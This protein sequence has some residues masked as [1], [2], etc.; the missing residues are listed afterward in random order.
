MTWTSFL[1]TIGGAYIL[2]YTVIIV[3]DLFKNSKSSNSSENTEVLVFEENHQTKS[4]DDFVSTEVE[5]KKSSNNIIPRKEENSNEKEVP[6]KEEASQEDSPV[7]SFSGGLQLDELLKL[8]RKE[9][10]IKTSQIDF[11]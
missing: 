10:I 8:V 6:H 5:E 1:I 11:G 4:V 2:Y 9:S 3:L 7:E